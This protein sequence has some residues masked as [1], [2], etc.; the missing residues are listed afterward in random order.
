M[1]NIKI[2]MLFL[3]A[4]LFLIS[5]TKE[6]I[7]NPINNINETEGL[8]LVKS[9]ESNDIKAEVFNGSGTLSV[10]FNKIFIRLTDKQGNYIK[11]SSISLLPMM[12][13]NMHGNTHQHSC[14]VSGI[15]KVEGKETLY[16][17]Y[18]VFIMPSGD[19]ENFWELTFTCNLD[20]QTYKIS[21]KIN[22]LPSETE[23]SKKF[24]SA[25]GS[26]GKKYFLALVE[27]AQPKIGVND[28]VVALFQRDDSGNFP[29]VDNYKMMVDPRMP[30]MGNHSAPGN[31]DLEQLSDGLYHGKVGFSMS[32]Y[33]KINLMLENEA[34]EVIKGEQVTLQNQESSLNFKLEF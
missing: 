19:S 18:I 2:F 8:L 23:F 11:Q 13:M 30:G 17:G 3:I 29:I 33:W 7:K 21:D 12:T 9:F 10:G 16:E 27:P 4:S 34:G 15:T 22:V 20:G 28:I 24:S 1:K 25:T 32:G 5:C 14:P 31:K 6:E 26:D